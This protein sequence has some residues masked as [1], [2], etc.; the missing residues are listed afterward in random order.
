MG[1]RRNAEGLIAKGAEI[2]EDGKIVIKGF[3]N[4]SMELLAQQIAAL[5]AQ[6]STISTAECTDEEVETVDEEGILD[7]MEE[8]FSRPKDGLF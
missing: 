8:W 6:E 4:A 3:G 7:P 1:A 5:A 2:I